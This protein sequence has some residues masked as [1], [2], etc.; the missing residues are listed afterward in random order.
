MNNSEYCPS[1]I[2]RKKDYAGPRNN[3]GGNMPRVSVLTPIYNTKHSHLR[4]CIESILNQSYK[5]IELIIVDDN[6]TDSGYE[7]IEKY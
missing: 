6:S 7:I 3:K 4:E 2:N 5:N 1:A